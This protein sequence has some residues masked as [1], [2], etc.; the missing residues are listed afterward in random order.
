MII[1]VI[2]LVMISVF[3]IRGMARD[4]KVKDIFVFIC[5][6]IITFISGYIYL[7]NPWFEKGIAGITMDFLGLR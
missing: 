5:M 4:N 7:S 6:V 1:L 3:E 2:L